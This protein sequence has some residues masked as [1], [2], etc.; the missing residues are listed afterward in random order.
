MNT[1]PGGFGPRQRFVMIVVLTVIFTIAAAGVIVVVA[2][3]TGQYD[4]ILLAIPPLIGVGVF[5]YF[6]YRQYQAHLRAE[7][8]PDSGPDQA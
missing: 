1:K 6:A 4:T 7:N 8:H 3:R 2:V 5:A